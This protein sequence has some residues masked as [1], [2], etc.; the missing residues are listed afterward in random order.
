MQKPLKQQQQQ[1]QC[2]ISPYV[3]L[4]NNNGDNNICYSRSL[5]K[6]WISTYGLPLYT[7]HCGLSW[8]LQVRV[9]GWWSCWSPRCS[10]RS[11]PHPGVAH[12]STPVYTILLEQKYI[13]Q[14]TITSTFSDLIF[15][16][17][18][19]SDVCR[20]ICI[21]WRL[22]TVTVTTKRWL[23]PFW[24]SVTHPNWVLLAVWWLSRRIPPGGFRLPE[25]NNQSPLM[26]TMQHC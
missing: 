5:L 4:N 15:F 16:F 25:R 14:N 1:K 24:C 3:P 13:I 10:T 20:E 22:I 17:F 21:F 12:G 6:S 11:H 7:L 26:S 2:L 19:Q 8:S 23:L 9:A 18:F